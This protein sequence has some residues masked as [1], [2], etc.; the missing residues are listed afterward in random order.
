LSAIRSLKYRPLACLKNL[1]VGE[2]D[3]A[4]EKINLLVLHR[5]RAP[6]GLFLQ[7]TFL[8]FRSLSTKENRRDMSSTYARTSKSL[9]PHLYQTGSEAEHPSHELGVALASVRATQMSPVSVMIVRSA[10]SA[11]H[12]A[13]S[14]TWDKGIETSS[15]F[16]PFHLPSRS[17]WTEEPHTNLFLFTQKSEVFVPWLC[18]LPRG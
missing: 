7:G 11:L 13:S 9:K 6:S 10:R 1:P 4:L 15:L 14:K 17:G 3:L 8:G 5:P 2:A 16:Q 12:L 18:R